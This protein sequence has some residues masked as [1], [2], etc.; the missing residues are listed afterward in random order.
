MLMTVDHRQQYLENL[1]GGLSFLIYPLQLLVDL[2][3][4]ASDWFRESLATRRQLQEINASLRTQQLVLNVQLQKMEAL[5]AEIPGLLGASGLSGKDCMLYIQ[6]TRGVAPRQHSYPKGIEPTVLM[7][8]WAKTMP[9]IP[10]NHAR[11]FTLDD[12][13]W[14]RCDIKMTSLLGNVM[15]NEHAMRNDCYETVHRCP[16]G[17]EDYDQHVQRGNR[18][19]RRC[20]PACRPAPAN[21][22]S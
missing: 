4:S 5:E 22:H 16:S 10:E 2:P 8:A 15:A 19:R 12:F 7:Y 17:S 6:V 9:D 13:R 14:Q 11:A 1:R 3:N 20:R 18:A 21:R